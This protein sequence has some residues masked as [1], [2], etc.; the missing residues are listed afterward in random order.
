MKENSRM[1]QKLIARAVCLALA[2]PAGVAVADVKFKPDTLLAVDS[3]RSTVIDGIVSNWGAV[4][5]AAE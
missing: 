4:K 1:N 5:A 3:N 2:F